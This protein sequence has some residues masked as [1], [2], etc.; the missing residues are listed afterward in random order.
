VVVA[1]D[2]FFYS[3]DW[4]AAIFTRGFVESPFTH[5]GAKGIICCGVVGVN[6]EYEA[7][8]AVASY[9]YFA[10]VDFFAGFPN[11]WAWLLLDDHGVA[12]LGCVGE[13]SILQEAV[14]S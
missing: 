11:A 1:V 12:S 9:Y 14:L 13:G 5:T 8:C 6:F 4:P 2:D 3:T 7:D 10:V